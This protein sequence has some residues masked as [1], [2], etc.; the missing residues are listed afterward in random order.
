MFQLG[1]KGFSQINLYVGVFFL[2]V[3]VFIVV[4]TVKRQTDSLKNITAEAEVENYLNDI[5]RYLSSPINCNQTL[6]GAPIND[7]IF[8]AI[9]LKQDGSIVSKYP[10]GSIFGNSK[11]KIISYKTSAFNNFEE[12]IADLGMINIVISLHKELEDNSSANIER[13]IKVY[14]EIKAQEIQKCAFGGLPT[15]EDIAEKS[16]VGIELNSPFIGINTQVMKTSLNVLDTLTL[17]PTDVPCTKKIIGSLQ[18]NKVQKQFEQ[19]K[20]SL[21]WEKVHR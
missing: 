10:V 5:K 7:H 17:A 20:K 6:K 12:D 18:F 11:T 21:I 9:D 8:N 16:A 4:H 13:S 15:G 14:A 2:A 3:V 1:N 19:C